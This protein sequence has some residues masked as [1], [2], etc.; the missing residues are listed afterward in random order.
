MRRMALATSFLVA[1][2][3]SS[4][5]AQGIGYYNSLR[6]Y[7][8]LPASELLALFVDERATGTDDSVQDALNRFVGQDFLDA[9]TVSALIDGLERLA[10]DEGQ[11]PVVKAGAANVLGLAAASGRHPRVVQLLI[12]VFLDTEEPRVRRAILL[13]F[14]YLPNPADGMVLYREVLTRERPA[15]ASPAEASDA[16]SA[17]L[18]AGA[19]GRALLREVYEAGTV[20]EPVARRELDR[21]H[22]EGRL[23]GGGVI[24]GR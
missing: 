11:A 14:A 6:Y 2:I 3:C 20:K 22:R 17:A 13:M 10:R 15:F 16:V 1:S 24:E 4:L 23:R 8:S 7:A 18:A 21:L 9:E 12:D 5:T 19:E